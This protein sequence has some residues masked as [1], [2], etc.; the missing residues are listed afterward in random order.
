M[1]ELWSFSIWTFFKSIG[2]YL[3][4]QV[5]KLAIGGFAG[6]AA[7]GRYEVAVDV[8]SSP[9]LEINAPMISVLFPVMAKTLGDRA[10]LKELY[11][12]VLYWSVLICTSTAVGVAL[13][14]SDLVDAVLGPQW[15]DVKPLMPWLA[16]AYGFTGIVWSVYPAFDVI[17]KPQVSARLQWANLILLSCCVVPAALI[18]KSLQ[19]VVEARFAFSLLAVPVMFW[20]L[21]KEF[22]L[23]R[24]DFF[25][26]FWR[27]LV[28][29]ATMAC[30]VLAIKNAMVPGIPRLLA[31]VGAGALAYVVSIMVIW[32]LIGFPDGPEKTVW[33]LL[34]R[35]RAKTSADGAFAKD[36]ETGEGLLHSRAVPV[37]EAE[38]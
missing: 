27:P 18:F 7:M 2:T 34:F 28:A 15:Q 11:L 13:V 29:S 9:S 23:N 5:D 16:I 36:L 14:T 32:S 35:T 38:K 4:S 33:H 12:T 17:G 26:V 6:A 31:C 19:V 8:S 22:D 25:L 37:A 3:S 1:R 24:R 21:A 20:F 10:K 30:A